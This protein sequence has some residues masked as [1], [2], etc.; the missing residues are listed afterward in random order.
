MN[1]KGQIALVLLPI[2][3]LVFS[4]VA[5]FSFVSFDDSFETQSSEISEMISD[6][7]LSEV[8]I[9]KIVEISAREVIGSGSSNLKNDFKEE[10]AKRDLRTIYSG[11]FFGLVRNDNFEFYKVGESYI[12]KVEGVS[13]FSKKEFNSM[14]RN[15]DLEIEFDSEGNVHNKLKKFNQS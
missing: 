7:E 1:R 9:F 6:V 11:N 14:R 10:I 2:V 5:L 12:L 3:A 8:Y 13:L 15:F 4:G